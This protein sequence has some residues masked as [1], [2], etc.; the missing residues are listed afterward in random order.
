MFIDRNISWRVHIGKIVSK[1][2]Q[3]VGIIARARGF[4]NG[5]QLFLLY[6]TMVLP[7]LQYCLINW[8]NF[9]G[10][11]NLG[12]RDRLLTLQKSLVRIIC[13]AGR[14]SHADPLFAELATLKIDDLFAQSV[15]IFSYKLS[16]DMLPGA[17]AAMISLVKH[18][19]S[20]RGAKNNNFFLTHSDGRSIKSIA[21]GYWNSLSVSLK[22][23][24][25]IATFKEKSKLDLLAPYSNFVCSVR[26]CRSCTSAN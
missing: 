7:H 19:Y 26:G 25:S 21:P 13:G 12:L 3:T 4:M 5:P 9:K 11:R 15:R 22:E 8:G 6:N 18:G 20:T 23:S 16:K 24:V 14:I 2:S 10:D 1:I 17:L